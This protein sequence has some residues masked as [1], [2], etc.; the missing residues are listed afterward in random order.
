MAILCKNSFILWI[1]PKHLSSKSSFIV[2]YISPHLALHFFFFSL[3][4]LLSS[5]EVSVFKY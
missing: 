5:K 4:F 3:Q 1:V 2:A